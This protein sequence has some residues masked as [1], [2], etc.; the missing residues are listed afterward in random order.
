MKK[1]ILLLQ[2][3]T[4]FASP[5]FALDNGACSMTNDS[6]SFYRD[7]YIHHPPD[8]VNVK[9]GNFYYPLQDLY[10]PCF[11]IPLEVFRAY[12]SY[13]KSNGPFGPGWTF[14]YDIRI[15]LGDAG[16]LKVIESRRRAISIKG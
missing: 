9:T 15:A 12:N 10:L 8:P 7:F 16:T 6:G 3:V 5:C 1:I 2:L 13:N 11:G 14:N 4:I